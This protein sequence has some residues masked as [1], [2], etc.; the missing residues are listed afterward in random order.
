MQT[1]APTDPSTGTPRRA[2]PG[3]RRVDRGLL[4]AS[5][6]LATGAVLVVYATLNAITGDERTKLPAAI[7]SISPLPDAINVPNRTSIV[8]DLADGYVGRLIVDDQAFEAPG[9]GAL[10]ISATIPPPP[11]PGVQVV[12]E[13]GLD[14]EPGTNRLVLVPG[15]QIGIE[16]WSAGTHLVTV[17]FWPIVDGPDNAEIYRWQFAIV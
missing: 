14:F 8:V 6:V 2:A 1:D 3:R 17:E 9:S 12:R 5:L 7:E 11:E 13:P 4:I 16:R 15:P 10:Q